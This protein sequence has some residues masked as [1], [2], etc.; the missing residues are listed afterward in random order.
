MTITAVN[1]NPPAYSP[2]YNE[3]MFLAT[4]SGTAQTNF[5]FVFDVYAND[6]VTLIARIKLPARPTDNKGLF[7]AKRVIENYLSYDLPTGGEAAGFYRNSGSFYKYTVKVGEEYGSPSPTVYANQVTVSGLYVWNAAFDW[8][9]FR[10]FL[11]TD[12]L[13]TTAAQKSLLT[14]AP[15]IQDIESSQNAW[16]SMMTA[17]SGSIRHGQF[18]KYDSSGVLLGTLNIAS[19]H[20]PINEDADRFLRLACGTAN[21]NAHTPGWID[22][23]VSY[24][25]VQVLGTSSA[26]VSQLYRYDV[27][28]NCRF[29][30]VRLHWL[31]K[32]GGWDSFNFTLKSFE[33]IKVIKQ[34]FNRVYGTTTGTWSYQS[35]DRGDTVYDSRGK[36]AFRINSDWITEEESTWLEELLLSP[37]VYHEYD[38]GTFIGVQIKTDTYEKQK[39]VNRRIFNISLEFEYS[40]D[41]VAQR[42]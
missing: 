29:T 11:Y 12:Y 6:G 5:R 7:D 25:T 41:K 30:T 17:S 20:D 19:T 14:N 8:F 38:S 27:Q 40:F 3:N 28:S 24:Y 31:N 37:E 18:K 23:N 36:P 22:S 10:N 9:E 1:Q 33:S 34:L 2:A 39:K 35:S 21:L 32:R 26:V 13:L 15:T 42:G 4:S 16:L